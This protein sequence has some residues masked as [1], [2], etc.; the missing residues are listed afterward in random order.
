MYEEKVNVVGTSP[1]KQ[2]VVRRSYK[3][4]KARRRKT[5]QVYVKMH[6]VG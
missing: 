5:E 1:G 2:G 4:R 6:V 3:G